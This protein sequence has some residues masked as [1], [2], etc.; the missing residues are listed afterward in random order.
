MAVT[1]NTDNNIAHFEQFEARSDI[2]HQSEVKLK[3]SL[4]TIKI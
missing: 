1:S 2:R 3:T 4:S